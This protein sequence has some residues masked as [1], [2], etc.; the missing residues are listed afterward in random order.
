MADHVQSKIEAAIA[1]L[2]RALE[3]YNKPLHTR[4]AKD[5]AV[6]DASAFFQNHGA[7]VR[8]LVMALAGPDGADVKKY[9][10]YLFDT[11]TGAVVQP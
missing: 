3:T 7:L 5:W 11:A 6:I 9:P 2:D 8:G 10:L 1:A 4:D